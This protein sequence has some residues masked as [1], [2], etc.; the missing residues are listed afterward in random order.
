MLQIPKKEKPSYTQ[1]HQAI[2]V[3]LTEE[4]YAVLEK[5]AKKHA[6]SMS[7]VAR[8][9]VA[10]CESKKLRLF[11]FWLKDAEYGKV[12]EAVGEMGG[13]VG[14]HVRQLFNGFFEG[15]KA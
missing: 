1:S 7:E 13:T 12:K 8:H 2:K 3:Y 10:Q 15:E 14:A 9:I 6:C 11:T 4:E 5:L